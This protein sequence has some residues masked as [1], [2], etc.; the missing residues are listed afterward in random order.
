MAG[1]IT[2]APARP[3]TT[4]TELVVCLNPYNLDYC[5]YFGTRAMLEAEG[6]L[7]EN[8]NWPEGFDG[9]RWDDGR[10][11]YWLRRVRPEGIKGPKKAFLGVDWWM[12]RW[13]LLN[14]LSF[15]ERALAQKRKELED[16]L[17]RQSPAVMLE[18]CAAEKRYWAARKDDKFQ[19]FKA[20]VPGLVRPRRDRKPRSVTQTQ[21]A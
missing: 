9:N 18:S 19:A 10:F 5:E 11:K 4:P 7:P 1:Q 13:E 2:S 8:I 20:L 16:M 12:L 14:G 21:E 3:I 17:H 6:I 15:A